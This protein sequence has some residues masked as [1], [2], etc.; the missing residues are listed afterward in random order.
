MNGRI[1]DVVYIGENKRGE[2][3]YLVKC[4]TKVRIKKDEMME[5]KI[6]EENKFDIGLKETKEL[7][8]NSIDIVNNNKEIPQLDY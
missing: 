6:L 5:S 4:V 2:K 1:I 3:Q 8:E 7:M